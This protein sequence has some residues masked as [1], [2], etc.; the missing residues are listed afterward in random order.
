MKKKIGWA[1]VW[2]VIGTLWVV[3]GTTFVSDAAEPEKRNP[4]NSDV[5]AIQPQMR[6]LENDRVKV[7]IDLSVGGAVTFLADKSDANENGELLNMINSCDWGRQIQLSYYSGPNPFIGPNGEE[8]TPSWAGLGWNPIQAGDAGGYPS[9]VTR[10]EFIEGPEPGERSMVVECIPK[11]WPHYNVP[12]DCTFQCLYTLRN[13]ENAFRLRATIRL[14]RLDHTQY[15]GRSQEMPA[16]YTNGPWY[17]LVTYQGERPF[18]NQPLRTLVQKGDGKG[19]PWVQ[20][21]IPERW[22]ALVNDAGMGVGVYQPDSMYMTAGFHPGDV[23]KGVGG[24]KD[25][26]TGYIAP[27]SSTILDWNGESTYDAFFIVG[28]LDEIREFVYDRAPHEASTRWVFANDR[29]HWVYEGM[30]DAGWPISEALVFS[31]RSQPGVLVGPR[32]FWRAE[33]RKTLELEIAAQ[34][35]PGT[36]G[37]RGEDGETQGLEI[38]ANIT[39]VRW[40]DCVDTYDAA[41][42]K[43]RGEHAGESERSVAAIP[44]S[45]PVDG[46]FHVVRVE[47]DGIAGYTGAMKQLRLTLPAWNA[48]VRIKRVEI[49]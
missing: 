18:E 37:E 45:I 46:Q 12:G 28:S 19:W 4:R 42:A 49:K 41:R 34:P 2:G 38:A 43:E 23:G 32:T 47:L 11:Q 9:V 40:T 21:Y 10:F 44:I 26:Q 48:E 36:N 29:Q 7:G 13:E 20:A 5:A 25:G 1:R 8:P 14:N 27:L 33:S 35:T 3:M 6:Y 39:P 17:K 30:T 16:L 22:A 24:P 15:T 31:P